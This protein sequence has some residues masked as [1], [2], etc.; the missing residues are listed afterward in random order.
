SECKKVKEAV[1]KVFGNYKEAVLLEEINVSENSDKTN[2]MIETYK[3]T[4]VPTIVFIDKNGAVIN[5]IE[6]LADEITIK[7]NLDKIK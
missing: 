6:G 3:I 1:D 5:K 7:E 4:V 2:G